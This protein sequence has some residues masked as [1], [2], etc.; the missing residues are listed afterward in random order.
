MDGKKKCSC[1][2]V[3]WNR[4]GF[5]NNKNVSDGKHSWCKRCIRSVRKS[6]SQLDDL[7]VGAVDELSPNNDRIFPLAVQVKMGIKISLCTLRKDMARLARQGDIIRL[8]PRSGY[9]SRSAYRAR[10]LCVA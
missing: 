8:G 4:D 6:E 3:W 1:C 5:Y 7:I 2:G 10:Q 9:L